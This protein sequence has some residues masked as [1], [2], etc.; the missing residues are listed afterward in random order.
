MDIITNNKQ[1]LKRYLDDLK[2]MLENPKIFLF[3]HFS[4]LINK[5]DFAAARQSQIT[6][7]IRNNDNLMKINQ[8]WNRMFDCIKGFELECFENLNEKLLNNSFNEIN[9]HTN[10]IIKSCELNLK[11]YKEL[12]QSEI[13]LIDELL[14][15]ETNRIKRVLFKNK[16]LI[17]FDRQH[18]QKDILIFNKMKNNIFFGKLI[19]VKDDYIGQMGI[20][21]LTKY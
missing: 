1:R 14:Y 21:Y 4:N 7:N 2:W 12:T 20:D 8:I 16:S 3:D 6:K 18:Q 9:E 5:I 19:F 17:F 10:E 15:E 11:R 13:E